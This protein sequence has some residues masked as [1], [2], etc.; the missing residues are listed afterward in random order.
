MDSDV[1]AR[2][3]A[4]EAL[5]ESEARLRGITDSTQDAIIMMDHL[6]AISF[7]NPAA[8]TTL[9]YR[10]DEVIG[11]N[12][13]ELLTPERYLDAHRAKYPEFLRS[14]RG[15]AVGRTVELAAR[16]KDG[17]E[18]V[19]ALSLSAVSRHGEW[20][21]V[22]ILRDITAQKEAERQLRDS[23]TELKRTEAALLT[24][25]RELEA[26]TARA[27]GLA[28]RAELASI[29]KSEFL[30]N[31]SHEIRTPMNGVIGMTGLLL[32][33]TLTADQRQY[34]DIVRT[35][36][37]ALLGIINDIL[38]FSKIEAKRLDLEVLDFDLAALLEDFADTLAVRAQEKGVE[39]FCWAE[40]GVPTLLRG[41]PGRL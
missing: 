5:H 37:E 2:T 1:T 24:T 16:R 8:E 39:L 18:I 14:G 7:W 40:P 9:G 12:L 32:D 36:G 26:A 35:S 34:V 20:H 31:M 13:H 25:N 30:A 19:I 22:G 4:E 33:T 27:N 3:Q 38:D 21:A 29:A 17:Q 41:D 6:G 15:D 23:I 28:L 10:A 11:R